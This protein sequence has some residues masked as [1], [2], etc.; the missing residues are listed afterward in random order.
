MYDPLA[1][2]LAEDALASACA[3]FCACKVAR[4]EALVAYKIDI[5]LNSL[6]LGTLYRAQVALEHVR[7]VLVQARANY[8]SAIVEQ[9]IRDAH[10]RAVINVG[11]TF[12]E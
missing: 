6:S 5:T 11:G 1:I 4:D 12:W 9:A 2:K 7:A 3:E 8:D 10:T